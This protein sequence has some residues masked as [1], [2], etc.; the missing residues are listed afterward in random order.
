MSYELKL[1]E[2][3]DEHLFQWQK[4]GVKK[5]LGKIVLLIVVII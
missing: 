3:T 4:S 1:A 5:D 2:E